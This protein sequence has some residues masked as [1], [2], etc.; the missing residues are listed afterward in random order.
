MTTL[1]RAVPGYTTRLER[2]SKIVRE[3]E[4]AGKP[5]IFCAATLREPRYLHLPS[6]FQLRDLPSASHTT[7]VS[8]RRARVS[9]CFAFRIH[10]R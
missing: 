2:K 5:L 4:L 3:L 7:D 6:Y 1:A 8:M 10:S 9:A